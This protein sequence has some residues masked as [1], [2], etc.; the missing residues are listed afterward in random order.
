MSCLLLLLMDPDTGLPPAC[1]QLLG[2]MVAGITRGEEMGGS[3][4]STLLPEAKG[5]N[6]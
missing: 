5:E 4:V 3:M 1:V 2:D 6:K